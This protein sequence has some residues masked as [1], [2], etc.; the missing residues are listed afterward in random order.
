MFSGIPG[1]QQYKAKRRVSPAAATMGNTINEVPGGAT[2]GTTADLA[3]ATRQNMAESLNQNRRVTGQAVTSLA[4]AAA[5]TRDYYRPG[6]GVDL[7]GLVQLGTSV[8]ESIR[9]ANRERDNKLFA[10]QAE[11]LLQNIPDIITKEAGGM[12]TAQRKLVELIDL[13]G[14]KVDQNVLVGYLPRFTETMGTVTSSIQKVEFEARKNLEDQV[15]EGQYQEL[16]HQGMLLVQRL[17]PGQGGSTQEAKVELNQLLG[18][19]AANYP[20]IVFHRFKAGLFAYANEELD[21][22]SDE[23]IEL[24]RTADQT[25]ELRNQLRPYIQQFQSGKLTAEDLSFWQ[26]RII[27]EKDLVYA[28]PVDVESMYSRLQQA[29]ELALDLEKARVQQLD[30]SD[31]VKQFNQEASAITNSMVSAIAFNA[32]HSALSAGE[33]E[34]QWSMVETSLGGDGVRATYLGRVRELVDAGNEFKTNEPKDWQVILDYDAE[35]REVQDAKSKAL[36]EYDQGRMNEARQALATVTSLGAV[37]AMSMFKTALDTYAIPG[38]SPDERTRGRRAFEL[39]L[40][41]GVNSIRQERNTALQFYTSAYQD[42]M[43]LGAL[44]WLQKAPNGRVQLRPIGTFDNVFKDA[45]DWRRVNQN[46]LNNLQRQRQIELSGSGGQ[47]VNF[48]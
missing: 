6:G 2:S 25:A 4:N 29:T 1:T 45:V 16:M 48:R 30:D 46:T 33:F 34:Q 15:Q 20:E 23:L 5:D 8:Y 44:G 12:T 43:G 36:V 17:K 10:E 41:Q 22:D 38:L 28:Q 18:S 32:T 9:T 27:V 40:D 37:Q 47:P 31:L 42:Y 19:V 3:S 35:L 21:S 7:S 26:D 11:L 13:W 39:A 24:R 14:D